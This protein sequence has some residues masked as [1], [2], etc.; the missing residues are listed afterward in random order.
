VIEMANKILGE[1]WQA[2]FVEKAQNGGIEKVL[3]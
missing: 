1:N 3:L 2:E